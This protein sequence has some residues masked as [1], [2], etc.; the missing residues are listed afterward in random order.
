MTGKGR[1]PTGQRIDV[2]IPAELVERIDAEA[3]ENATTRV[4]VIRLIISNHYT[5]GATP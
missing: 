1:P 3:A 2:R 4:E 5:K